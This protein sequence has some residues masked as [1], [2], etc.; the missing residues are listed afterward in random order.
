MRAFALSIIMLI[1]LVVQ[2]LTAGSRDVKSEKLGVKSLSLLRYL[3][4]T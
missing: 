1:K 2:A 3:R 4:E